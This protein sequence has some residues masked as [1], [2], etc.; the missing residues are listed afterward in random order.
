MAGIIWTDVSGCFPELAAM[1][2]PFQTVALS[3]VNGAGIA[4][5]VF[6]GEAADLTKSARIFYAAHLAELARRRGA[7][8][9]ITA[10]SEGGVSQSYGMLTNP[11]MLDLTSYGNLFR[12]IVM[13]TSARAGILV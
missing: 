7:G 2:V 5:D 10:Q 1:P 12:Q 3:I 8:G 9:P 11:R 6:G 4:V 13:G